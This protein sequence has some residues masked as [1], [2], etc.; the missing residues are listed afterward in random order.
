MLEFLS[1]IY[2]VRMGVG[3]LFFNKNKELL[4]VKTSYRDYWT[5]PGGL[6]DKG[7]SPH[8]ACVR[9]VEEELGIKKKKYK[10]AG[11]IYLFRKNWEGDES[12][13]FF[14]HGGVINENQIK[15][16]NHEVAD[17]KFVPLKEISKYN[18]DIGMKLQKGLSE[19]L[20][21]GPTYLEEYR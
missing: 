10:F 1:G 8:T 5:I 21:N 15:I 3:A 19:L 6:T 9:E 18:K 2:A 13:Q 17:Y 14:F 16:D 7:E 4:M 12:L 20:K 11:L